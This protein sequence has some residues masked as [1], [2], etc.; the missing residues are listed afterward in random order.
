MQKK[1]EKLMYFR[2]CTIGCRVGRHFALSCLPLPMELINKTTRSSQSF[3][4]FFR[5]S[6]KFY[7]AFVIVEPLLGAIYF[8]RKYGAHISVKQITHS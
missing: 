7:F 4:N 2:K 6:I 5:P 3:E 8:L 1:K